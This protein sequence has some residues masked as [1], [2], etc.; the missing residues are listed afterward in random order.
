[1]VIALE[2]DLIFAIGAEG[3]TRQ[4]INQLT[5]CLK[6]GNKMHEA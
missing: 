4:S 5:V 6:A 1:M 3:A 2:S